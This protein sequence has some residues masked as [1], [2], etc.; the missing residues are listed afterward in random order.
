MLKIPHFGKKTKTLILT[1]LMIFTVAV[2]T[3]LAYVVS[4]TN[5]VK[6][7]FVPFTSVAGDLVINKTVN[8]PFGTEYQIPDH[9]AFDFSVELGRIYAGS[10]V[11]TTAG[12][13]VADE[14]G[15][16]TLTV[17]PGSPVGILGIDE[18]TEVTVTEIQKNGSGFAALNGELTKKATVTKDGVI[19][20]F[21]N[22]YTP[23]PAT[24]QITVLGKKVLEI[25]DKTDTAVYEY[26]FSFLLERETDGNWTEVG[27]KTLSYSTADTDPATFD[28]TDLI[29]GI[30]FDKAGNY[31]FRLTEVEGTEDFIKYDKAE[32]HFTVIVGDADMDGTLEVQNVTSTENAVTEKAA[33]GEYTVNVTFTNV[34]TGKIPGTSDVNI[35]LF[36]I[37]LAVAAAVAIAVILKKR[38]RRA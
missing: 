8:H 11:K 21:T 30:T 19:V 14:N 27:T 24:P 33:S 32:N 10:T 16:V 9:V 1:L 3:T 18:N 26:S 28:V 25:P 20:N 37:T 12:D 6:N 17:K 22:V 4:V 29:K 31:N 5:P 35:T 38:A 34:K 13:K 2:Q 7:T 36:A 23:S 15:T